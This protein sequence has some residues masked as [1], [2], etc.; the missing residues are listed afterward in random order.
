MGGEG[1]IDG[2]GR[3]LPARLPAPRA[4]EGDEKARPTAGL[5][6]GETPAGMTSTPHRAWQL[7]YDKHLQ[8][9]LTFH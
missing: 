9:T 2:M 5:G 8:P 7:L 3:D 4:P 6:A 1:A